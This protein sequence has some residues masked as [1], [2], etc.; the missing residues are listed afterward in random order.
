MPPWLIL[1]VDLPDVGADV[2]ASVLQVAV[3]VPRS[4]ARGVPGVPGHPVV[5]GRDHWSAIG[6]EASGDRARA[7]TSRPTRT[8]WSRSATSPPADADAPDEL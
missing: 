7:T 1:L 8:P 5:I 3:T 2:V 4:C 6:D